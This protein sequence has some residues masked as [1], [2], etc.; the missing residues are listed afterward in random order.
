LQV[1]SVPQPKSK[2]AMFTPA[3][4]TLPDAEAVAPELVVVAPGAAE[5]AG[6][7]AEPGRHCE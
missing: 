2:P 3:N 6:A 1:P 5:E 4:L 7:G